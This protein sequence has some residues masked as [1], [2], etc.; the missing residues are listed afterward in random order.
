MTV[1]EV[2]RDLRRVLGDCV[3][4]DKNVSVAQRIHFAAAQN[5][6]SDEEVISFWLSVTCLEGHRL[7][8]FIV[9]QWA[10][11]ATDINEWMELLEQNTT[12]LENN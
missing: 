9:E 8:M 1:T 7:P 11:Q 6:C 3:N 2:A 4:A 10:A 5:D 12:R